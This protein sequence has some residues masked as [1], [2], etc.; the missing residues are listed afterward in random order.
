MSEGREKKL[1]LTFQKLGDNSISASH[2]QKLF[3]VFHSMLTGPIKSGLCR[4]T[5]IYLFQISEFTSRRFRF[6]SPF[7]LSLSHFHLRPRLNKNGHRGERHVFIMFWFFLYADL[8]LICICVGLQS[9]ED[10]KVFLTL[11]D[12]KCSIRLL[13]TE[14]ND[15]FSSCFDFPVCRLEADLYL[16]WFTVKRRH[17]SP[18]D[19][20]W[21]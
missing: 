21:A 19:S 11:D 17:E 9:N 18:P 1:L 15:T 6:L 13:D 4:K 20:R 7:S 12:R 5:R 2:F 8:N 3:S 16:C 10:M 14:V